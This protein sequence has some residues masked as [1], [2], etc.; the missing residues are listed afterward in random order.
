MLHCLFSVQ[1]HCLLSRV[2]VYSV[3][4]CLLFGLISSAEFRNSSSSERERQRVREKAGESA[5]YEQVGEKME[6]QQIREW[7]YNK[8]RGSGRK[9]NKG[10]EVKELRR[11][12]GLGQTGIEWI[13]GY[14]MAQLVQMSRREV[15]RNITHTATF[16]CGA[17][18][19]SF[20]ESFLVN[21]R[22]QTS[23]TLLVRCADISKKW[24]SK[25]C[26]KKMHNYIRWPT[27]LHEKDISAVCML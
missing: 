11:S 25:K 1:A 3:C 26:N 24:E 7:F 17:F 21:K 18:T 6:V 27:Q 12:W 10:E 22:N 14:S 15:T 19:A 20:E 13:W 23:H 8:T 2:F 5:R 9:K 4:L 16:I